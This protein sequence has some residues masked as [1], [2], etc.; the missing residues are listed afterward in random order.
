M[1]I[2]EEVQ[3]EPGVSGSANPDLTD[4]ICPACNNPIFIDDTTARDE[5]GQI[6][7]FDC[8]IKT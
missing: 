3:L 6:Y 8:L 1:K 5:T 4:D 7:Y 2:Y